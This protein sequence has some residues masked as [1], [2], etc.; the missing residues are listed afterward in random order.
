MSH[1]QEA[2][3]GKSVATK[4]VQISATG[5]VIDIERLQKESEDMK[6]LRAK[7]KM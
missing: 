2:L 4:N 5:R 7:K 1:S 3:K 6:E